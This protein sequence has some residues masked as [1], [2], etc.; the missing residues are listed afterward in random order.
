MTTKQMRSAA[1]IVGLAVAATGGTAVAQ[2][3]ATT[4]TEVQTRDE[5]FDDW[6][7]LGL[8]GLAGLLGRRK[9]DKPDVH[10]DHTKRAGH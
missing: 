10:I 6:G 5:G 4:T 8:L 3:V 2:E 7:L 1:V 9:A